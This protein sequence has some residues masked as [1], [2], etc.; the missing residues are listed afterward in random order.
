[1]AASQIRADAQSCAFCQPRRLMEQ[2]SHRGLGRREPK[3]LFAALLRADLGSPPPKSHENP[4]ERII[5]PIERREP[6]LR[7][8]QYVSI[9][10]IGSINLADSS[11]RIPL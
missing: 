1:M 8:S 2:E 9:R 4:F 11:G 6:W 5:P 3:G 10:G 7:R